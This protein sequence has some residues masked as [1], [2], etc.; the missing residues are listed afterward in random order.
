MILMLERSCRHAHVEDPTD[1]S[2]SPQPRGAPPAFDDWR[3]VDPRLARTLRRL[4][5]SAALAA[6]RYAAASTAPPARRADATA[7]EWRPL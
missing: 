4:G 3:G 5:F 6:P 7:P 1:A 2:A